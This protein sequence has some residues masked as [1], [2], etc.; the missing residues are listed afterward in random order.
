MNSNK[1]AV[2]RLKSTALSHVISLQAT[3]F[4]IMPPVFPF[5][6]QHSHL[7][8]RNVFYCIILFLMLSKHFIL[9]VVVIAAVVY[10]HLFILTFQRIT[11]SF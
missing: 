5:M 1:G 7:G 4:P 8:K 3:C 10:A 9:F 11:C 2:W 6:P